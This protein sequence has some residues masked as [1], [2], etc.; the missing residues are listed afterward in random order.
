MM[1]TKALT[2]AA[3]LAVG[4]AAC[5]ASYTDDAA[6]GTGAG[7]AGIDEDDWGGSGGPDD[8]DGVGPAVGQGGAQ[9]FGQFRAILDAGDIP[10]PETIDSVGFFAEHRIDLGAAECGEDVCLNGA[11]AVMGNLMTGSNCTMVMMGM[12]TPIDLA[13]EPRLPLN[14][15]IAID[16]SGSM[17]GTPIEYVRS[18]L[19]QMREALHPEDTITLIGFADDAVILAD[20][21]AADDDALE[22]AIASLN[23]DGSTNVYAGLRAA[24][25]HVEA[26][27]DGEHQNRVILLSDGEATTGIVN[28]AR[29]QSLAESYAH[30]GIAL[31]TIGMGESFNPTL[32]RRLS[33]VGGGAFYFVEDPAAVEEVFVEEVEA[34]LLPLAQDVVIDAEIAE[35]YTLRGVFGT[36]QFVLTP[37]RTRIEIPALQLA[38]R[39]SASDNEGG[40]RG[41]GGA[42][43]LELMPDDGASGQDVG[44]LRIAYDTPRD[45]ARIEQEVTIASS[46]QPGDT[47]ADGFFGTDGSRKAFVTLNLYVGF[48]MAATRAAA[49]DGASALNV[50]RPLRDAVALWLESF[51]DPDIEDDLRYVDRFIEN[52]EARGVE[53]PMQGGGEVP[54]PPE[55]WPQ[56]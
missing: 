12:T 9:D 25:E 23:A 36:Q 16:T 21:V 30:E 15:A 44:T 2:I 26:R 17:R 37:E 31:S 24:L 20:A 50:L 40:R 47:P 43:V 1:N 28:D 54:P 27:A 22:D 11:L 18:G 39:E 7:G 5:D 42:I 41:G 49:G 45:E 8:G 56:D 52:L 19:S 46:L 6:A 10:G 14:L 32:M 3:M 48:E 53:P 33:E 4:S 34:F 29:V 35:G 38:H 55:P 51:P 13:E